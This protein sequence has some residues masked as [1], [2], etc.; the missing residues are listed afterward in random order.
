M[1]FYIPPLPTQKKISAVLSALDD[2]IELNNR[3]NQNLEQQA[4]AVFK[5]WFVDKSDS[6]RKTVKAEEFFD[7]SIGRTPPRKEPEWFSVNAGDIVWISIA[8]MGNCGVYISEGS[9]YLTSAAVSRFKVKIVPDNT[10]ILSFK[11][12]VG[13][14]AI[15]DGEVT[16]NEAIAHFVTDRK[17]ITEYLY[18]YLKNFNFQTMGSTS[19]IATAVNLKII[20]AMPFIVPTEK[21]I[22]AFHRACLPMFRKIKTNQRENA[23]LTQ[24]RDTLLPKLMSGEI[25]VSKVDISDDVV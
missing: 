20:K 5:S 17:E 8:D 10:V 14:I 23:R 12:T 13:R 9:E 22:S 11:L 15:T 24:L 21:E 1:E 6:E 16:T 7:I 18:C 4:Q 3:I 2:K 25:D 19:S